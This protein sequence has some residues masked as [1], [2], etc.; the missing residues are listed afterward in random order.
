MRCC[1]AARVGF[2]TDAARALLP[3]ISNG[4][5]VLSTDASFLIT[6]SRGNWA[7]NLIRSLRFLEWLINRSS[8]LVN[9]HSVKQLVLS[10]FILVR[11]ATAGLMQSLVPLVCPLADWKGPG[12]TK[13]MLTQWKLMKYSRMNEK[14]FWQHARRLIKVPR[15][16]NKWEE[17]KN[18]KPF[19]VQFRNL[20]KVKRIKWLKV[21]PRITVVKIEK[22]VNCGN[23]RD[24]AKSAGRHSSFIQLGFNLISWKLSKSHLLLLCTAQF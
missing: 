19:G 11:D 9:S 22:N 13:E 24:T 17:A 12:Q 3:L 15:L 14:R 21:L 23:R 4:R 10:Y 16:T 18:W 2:Q 20:I 8:L 5:S 1:D 6:S 7:F